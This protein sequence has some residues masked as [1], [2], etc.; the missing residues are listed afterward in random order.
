MSELREFFRHALALPLEQQREVLLEP[1]RQ[2]YTAYGRDWEVNTAAF[3]D[4]YVF[5]NAGTRPLVGFADAH[6][7]EGYIAYHARMLETL[8]VVALELD[9]IR[10]LGENRVLVFAR[11][12]IRAGAG[13]IDQQVLDLSEWRDG[14]IF[15]QTLWFDREEGLRELGL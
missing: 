7:R 3:S 15:R 2:G 14:E 1:F 9:D 13:T 10:P 4:D 12:V 8:N 6:G 5:R 11:V